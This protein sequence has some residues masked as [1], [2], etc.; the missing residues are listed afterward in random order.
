MSSHSTSHTPLASHAGSRSPPF[1][2]SPVQALMS[3]PVH[4]KGHPPTFVTSVGVRLLACATLAV[5]LFGLPD[6]AGAAEDRDIEVLVNSYLQ[7]SNP[8]KRQLAFWEAIGKIAEERKA[9]RPQR[10]LEMATHLASLLTEDSEFLSVTESQIGELYVHLKQWTLAK[11]HF[12]KALR[13]EETRAAKDVERFE[14]PLMWLAGVSIQLGEFDVAEGHYVRLLEM[15]QKAYG[16]LTYRTI[17][18]LWALANLGLRQNDLSKAE[19]YIKQEL[20]I[21]ATKPEFFGVSLGDAAKA[22]QNLG[23]V[24]AHQG[25]LAD[26]I[27]LHLQARE[28]LQAPIRTASEE[29]SEV[30][31]GTLARA[32]ECEE[33]LTSLYMKNGNEKGAE[34]HAKARQ[35]LQALVTHPPYVVSDALWYQAVLPLP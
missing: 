33:R 25:N 13:L 19:R 30:G 20:D 29:G 14:A 8:D 32:I 27:S 22:L 17:G 21:W 6:Q 9:G 18:Q 26:A 7:A 5:L 3:T 12:M 16:A 1:M 23:A 15:R 10:A 4:S 31:A 2:Q 34:M 11:A 35:K 24:R 28:L